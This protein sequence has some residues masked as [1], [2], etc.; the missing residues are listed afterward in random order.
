M[1]VLWVLAE[2]LDSSPGDCFYPTSLSV[3]PPPGS[4]TS[5]P[6][7]RQET[8]PLLGRHPFGRKGKLHRPT[9]WRTMPLLVELA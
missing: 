3:F 1:R 9:G 7:V 8:G 4:G 2:K 6:T 5:L